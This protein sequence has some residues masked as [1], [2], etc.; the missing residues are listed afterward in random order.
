MNPEEMIHHELREGKVK[1]TAIVDIEEA[2][3]TASLVQDCF[4]LRNHAIRTKESQNKV[5]DLQAAMNTLYKELGKYHKKKTERS[6]R[7]LRE[8]FSRKHKFAGF[9]RA[10]V[11][12]NT[13]KYPELKEYV[14][15]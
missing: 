10:Y 12:D 11:R 5:R 1:I 3:N 8:M 4:E 9:T 15:L 14:S 6:L 2:K 13:E 7:I